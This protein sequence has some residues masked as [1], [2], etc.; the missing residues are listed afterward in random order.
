MINPVPQ[1]I[2]QTLSVFLGASLGVSL[3]SSSMALADGTSQLPA[4]AFIQEGSQI[5]IDG[6]QVAG[7]WAQ[8]TDP[9]SG[10]SMLG[11]S[12]SVWMRQLGG[13]LLDNTSPAQQPVRWFADSP[14]TLSA[15]LGQ[16][17]AVRYL[18]ISEGARQWGW[19]VQARGAVLDIQ[20]ASAVVQSIGLGQQPWGQRL[21]VRLDRAAPWRVSALTNSRTGRT[22]RKFTL[23]VDATLGSD[24]FKG[25][26]APA[27]AGLKALKV[28]R[29]P[30]QTLIHGSMDGRLQPQLSTLDNPPRLVLD[31]R[32]DPVRSRRILWA[33][34]IEWR[35]AIV[36]VGQAQFPVT[37][38]AVNPRQPGLKLLPFWGSSGSGIV[39]IAPL[40]KM[41]QQSQAAAAI[42]A[43]YFGRDRQSPLGAIRRDGTWIS[44]PIL[45]RGVVAWDARGRMSVGRLMLQEQIVTSSG[46]TLTVAS[47]NSGYPQKGIARYTAQWGASYSPVLKNEQIF[48]VI[49]DRVVSVQPAKEGMAFPIP[50]NGA[51]LVARSVTALSELPLGS[52][53]QY[54]M[55]PSRPEFETFPNIVGGGPVLVENGRVTVDAIAEQFSQNFATQAADRSGIGQ[56]ADGTILLAVTHN[57]IGG[58]GPTLGE[59][60]QVMQRL[61]T[62]NALNLDGGSSTSLYLGGQLLDRHPKTAARVQ[63]GIGVFLQPL[64]QSR[65]GL[66]TIEQKSLKNH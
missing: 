49:N 36:P 47:S 33:P 27:G 38:L 46:T 15:R 18:A 50:S 66:G 8:W 11:V 41:A 31:L 2:G 6:K 21:V 3:F 62:V 54:R 28:E 12:D 58:A 20:T 16:N 59:W 61:G 39:G 24:E 37:W 22:D 56:T 5:S 26:S 1:S 25:L 65:M 30:Q 7:A 32:Q 53:I 23:E 29:K 17:G 64:T 9:Q 13:D 40:S 45:N 48:T 35:E 51:L 10:Q 14:K 52:S 4:A 19:Q 57:R 63:N 34:G 55:Q 42:N 44:S 60:A 43:G